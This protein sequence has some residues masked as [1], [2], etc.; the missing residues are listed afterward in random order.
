MVAD[1]W[2]KELV[3]LVGELGNDGVAVCGTEEGRLR[4]QSWVVGELVPVRTVVP[5]GRWI[6]TVEG[7]KVAVQPW[8][9]R[10]P[11]DMRDPDARVGKM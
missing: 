1:D 2:R 3:A 11:T 7:K 5:F 4:H 10:T 8:S 6:E 9:Q